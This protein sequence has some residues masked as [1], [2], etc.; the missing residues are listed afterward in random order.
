MSVAASTW[1]W[2]LDLPSTEKLVALALA[3]HAND[4]DFTCWPSLTHLE[5]KTGLNRTTVWRAIDRLVELNLIKRVGNK[6]S[7]STI[8]LVQVGAQIT[9][10][11]S[12]PRCVAQRGRCAD[13]LGVGAQRTSNHKYNHQEPSEIN[14]PPLPPKGG[15]ASKAV[16]LQT[17]LANCKQQS[18]KPIPET[19]PVFAYAKQVNI[20]IE[21]LHLC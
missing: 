4:E 19:D 16:A 8:Y 3:D 18:V 1:A 21:F 9:Q 20:P 10:V 7:G 15:K 12:A 6:P 2:K 5:K 11:H 13:H 14:K 17:F